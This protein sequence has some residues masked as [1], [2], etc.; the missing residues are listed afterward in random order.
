MNNYAMNSRNNGA[1]L[2]LMVLM[3]PLTGAGIDIYVP[4]LPMMV[5]SFSTTEALVQTSIGI[6]LIG[7]S[8]SQFILG[9]CSDS[10]GRKRILLPSC[11]CYILVCFLLTLSKNIHMFLI[12]R[13]IQGL[14]VAGPGVI[15]KALLSD[16]YSG[17]KLKKASNYLTIAWATGPIVAPVI[18]GY[19]SHYFGWQGCFYFLMIYCTF[20]LLF[21]ACLLPE[22]KLQKEPFK[23]KVISK[24]YRTILAHPVFI[25]GFLFIALGYS[26]LTIFNVVGAFIIQ[27]TL[28]YTPVDFGH[29]ALFLGVFWF[30]GN[31]INRPLLNHFTNKQIIKGIVWSMALLM[32]TLVIIVDQ[33]PLSIY[34]VMVPTCLLCTFGGLMMPNGVALTLSLFPKLGGTVNAIF[35]A[36]YVMGASL[37]SLIASKLGT[38]TQ[39]PLL[40]SYLAIG[41]AA[42]F[43][44]Y[45]LLKRYRETN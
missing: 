14:A 34:T 44:Y 15:S 29:F 33:L 40:Y 7:Y 23:L 26:I 31:L 9:T 35:A 12:L 39:M 37:T 32:T 45:L 24:N 28:H 36:L 16:C 4:S 13:F 27:N 3:I 17:E 21:S 1:I 2:M 25:G 41:I 11:C 30:L 10:F 20:L 38:Q 18:G 6:Y 22:T 19:L 43:I 8:I 5:K 42:L